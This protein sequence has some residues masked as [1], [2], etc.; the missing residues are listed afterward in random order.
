[1]FEKTIA[2]RFCETDAL[3]HVSNTTLPIWFEDARQPVFEL[4]TPDLD[5]SNWPLILARFE[6]DFRAQIYY[7]QDVTLKTGISKLG[8]SSLEVYQEAWQNGILAA[9]GKTVLVHFDYQNQ[10]KAPIE[11]QLRT[12]LA[13]HLVE[14]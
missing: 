1:M 10:S 3:G 14:V 12:L 8:N 5:L 2:P 7:G 6:I 9:T 4:F 11:G 13:Q